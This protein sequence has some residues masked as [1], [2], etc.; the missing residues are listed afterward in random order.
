[1]FLFFANASI[2]TDTSFIFCLSFVCLHICNFLTCSRMICHTH[3]HHRCW[4]R[5]WW[6]NVKVYYSFQEKT[7]HIGFYGTKR[8]IHLKWSYYFRYVLHWN[9]NVQD[10]HVCLNIL[11]RK[12]NDYKNIRCWLS[13]QYFISTIKWFWRKRREII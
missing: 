13:N 9:E 11:L 5:R 10:I 8:C 3:Q 2:E 1:M 4:R 12:S 7:F 6:E